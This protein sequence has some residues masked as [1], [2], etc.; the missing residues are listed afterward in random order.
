MPCEQSTQS[1]MQDIPIRNSDLL[2][3]LKRLEKFA[4]NDVLQDMKMRGE[5]FTE[6]DQKW[7]T[8]I[9]YL[10]DVIA[11]G[12]EHDGYPATIKSYSLQHNTFLIND[13]HNPARV[14]QSLKE[15]WDC[16]ETLE[17]KYCLKTNALFAVYPPGGFI[18]WHNNANASAYNVIFTWSETGEG[19]F[20]YLD[21]RKSK[22][23]KMQ[24]KPGWQCKLGYFAAY[25][26][27]PADLVYHCAKTECWR[28]T[29]SFVFDRSEQSQKLQEWIIED[30]QRDQ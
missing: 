8:S 10:K 18:A 9:P 27:N 2:K 25:Q 16:L 22:I 14:R 4:T 19:D 26:D 28:M 21:R 1:D 29:I 15:I 17:T 23:I 6:K 7:Y 12:K 5:F 3:D 13:S 24:D 11:K 30:I 20:S